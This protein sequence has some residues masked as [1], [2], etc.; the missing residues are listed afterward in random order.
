[1]GPTLDPEDPRV[2]AAI[3]E[4]ASEF[5]IFTDH[6]GAVVVTA[7]AGLE[8]SGFQDVPSATGRHIAER[9]HPDDL[10]AVL[11]L[12][13]RARSDQQFNDTILAR[14]KGDDG[15]WRMF[16]ATV[17]GVGQHPV[18]G[19][20]A[21]IRVRATG[22][23]S[24]D[25]DARFSS[26]SALVPHGVLSGDVRGWVVFANDQAGQILGLTR[27]EILGE[28]W[29]RVVHA[30]D[31]E[32]A[33]DAGRRVVRQGTPQHAT[34][35]IHRGA[36]LRWVTL[37]VMP[38]G[39]RERRT[40]WV[41]TMED[42]T[43]SN[44]VEA[45]LAHQA[46]HDPLTGLPNRALLEDRL[47]QAD[48]RHARD[49]GELAVLFVDLDGFKAVNDSLGHHGGDD[50]LRIVAHRLISIVRPSDTVARVGG[51]EFVIVLEGLAERRAEDLAAEITRQLS[52]PIAIHG[53]TVHLGAS[54]GLAVARPGEPPLEIVSRAD[55]AMY[56]QKR[57][58]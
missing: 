1:V 32:D 8:S 4:F 43:E 20:G 24:D 39:D 56:Q 14:A 30:E 27:D 57:R 50:A 40:G 29:R 34:I 41:A 17:I 44:S 33:V 51:D 12:I 13:E 5:L 36:D 26:L 38:L 31:L 18:L 19:T 23:A 35:R 6:R 46:T 55:A 47:V 16:D 10:P 28:G 45:Q 7:G 52:Q 22:E 2:H 21:V 15:R 3:L 9:I 25:G 53:T 49:T 58:G 48:A 11:D 42:I 37:T 54:V